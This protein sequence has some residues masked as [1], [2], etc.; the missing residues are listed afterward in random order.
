MP[1]ALLCLPTPPRFPPPLSRIPMRGSLASARAGSARRSSPDCR[2]A[3]GCGRPAT[4]TW[5]PA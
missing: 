3:S 2:T 1:Q 5:T 4:Q